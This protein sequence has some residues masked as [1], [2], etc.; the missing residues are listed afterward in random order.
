MQTSDHKWTSAENRI[1]IKHINFPSLSVSGLIEAMPSPSDWG[2]VSETLQRR[3]MIAFCHIRSWEWVRKCLANWRKTSQSVLWGQLKASDW[4]IE[5]KI[6]AN[7]CLSI[8]GELSLKVMGQ[9]TIEKRS[10]PSSWN[11]TQ[12]KRPLKDTLHRVFAWQA[13]ELLSISAALYFNLAISCCRFCFFS[14]EISFE[15]SGHYHRPILSQL[16]SDSTLLRTQYY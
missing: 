2:K 11:D 3:W 1:I 6:I 14:S 16:S 7:C 12:T 10:F 4:E 8:R 9:V 5:K 13:N 15:C